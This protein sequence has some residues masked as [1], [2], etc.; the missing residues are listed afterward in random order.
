MRVPLQITTI[1]LELTE[2]IEETIRG[3]AEKLG[4]LY[5][6]ILRCRVRIG[7]PHRHQHKGILYYVRIDM[8]IPGGELVVNRVSHQD[9]YTA[10]HIAFDRAIRRLEEHLD[11]QRAH[12]KS[13]MEDLIQKTLL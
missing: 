3:K 10:I 6:R 9:L 5:D 13:Q 7:T 1:D 2:A 11:R 4:L 8:A 12:G